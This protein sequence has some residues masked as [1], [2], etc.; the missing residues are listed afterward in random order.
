MILLGSIDRTEI[1]SLLQQHFSRERRLG[2]W[3]KDG[4]TGEA[5]SGRIAGGPGSGLAGHTSFLF[6]DEEDADG[7]EMDAHEVSGGEMG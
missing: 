1:E 4:G 6:I 2:M 5:F 7:R 3:Q